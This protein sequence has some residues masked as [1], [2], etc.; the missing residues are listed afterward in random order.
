MKARYVCHCIRL[1]YLG[2]AHA[3][4][5]WT[6]N[7]NDGNRVVELHKGHREI[8][9]YKHNININKIFSTVLG[10]KSLGIITSCARILVHCISGLSCGG[11]HLTY[12][13]YTNGNT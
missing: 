12:H 7:A 1:F 11:W 13:T 9:R 3:V 10:L 2:S 8:T 6:S 4:I 5:L